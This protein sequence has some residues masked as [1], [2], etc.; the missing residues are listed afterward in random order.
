MSASHAT[1]DVEELRVGMYI[2][3]DTGWM[4]HPFP[5]SSFRISDPDQI[6]T[7]R[8][9]GLQ[10]LRWSP[11]RSAAPPTEPAPLARRPGA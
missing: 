4:S 6:R 5:L 7:I 11:D 10:Q 8:R 2:H 9:L 3:L 1:I